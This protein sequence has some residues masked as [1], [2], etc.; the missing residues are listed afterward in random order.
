MSHQKPVLIFDFDGTLVDSLTVLVEVFNRLPFRFGLPKTALKEMRDSGGTGLKS[1]IMH[2]PKWK[3]IVLFGVMKMGFSRRFKEILLYP[4]IKQVLSELH[5]EGY[6]LG[7]LSN[8]STSIVMKVLR[9]HGVY[10]YFNFTHCL[11]GAGSKS[12]ILGRILREHDISLKNCIYVGDEVDDIKAAHAAGMRC[13]AVSWG[14]NN[15]NDLE[16]A[17]PD[18]LIDDAANLRTIAHD[19]Y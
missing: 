16:A 7:L 10:R 17:N 2:Y 19:N 11:A 5:E 9:H 4:G 8:N 3:M 12:K 13:I 15:W 14:F 18:W 1:F 6:T